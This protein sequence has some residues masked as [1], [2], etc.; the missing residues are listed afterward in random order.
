MTSAGASSPAVVPGP[1]VRPAGTHSRFC[2][3]DTPSSVPLLSFGGHCSV[4]AALQERSRGTATLVRLE[5]CKVKE[6]QVPS[7]HYACP[8]TDGNCVAA[9][10]GGEQPEVDRQSVRKKLDSAS[11]LGEPARERRSH[12]RWPGGSVPHDT[13]GSDVDGDRMAGRPSM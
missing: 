6:V 5:A 13:G 1:I 12:H 4:N 9:R 3:Q 11:G 10:R 8:E 2:P 7:G